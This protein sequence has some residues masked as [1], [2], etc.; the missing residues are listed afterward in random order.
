L[1]TRAFLAARDA[2]AAFPMRA[3][4]KHDL[5]VIFIDFLLVFRPF[6]MLD[7]F[8]LFAWPASH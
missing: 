3:R 8:E 6:Q 2:D 5:A 1:D 7:D 4:A